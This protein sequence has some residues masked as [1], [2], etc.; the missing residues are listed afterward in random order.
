MKDLMHDDQIVVPAQQSTPDEQLPENQPRRIHVCAAIQLFLR[1][2]LGGHV[3]EFALGIARTRRGDPRF[4][5]R[6]AEV[7]DARDA[8]HPD[9]N[10]LR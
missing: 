4:R 3:N 8:I 10:V 9:Q 7:H 1:R 2:L 5:T 6:H